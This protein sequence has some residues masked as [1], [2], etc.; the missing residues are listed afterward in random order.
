MQL[1][2]IYQTSFFGLISMSHVGNNRDKPMIT[3]QYQMG[4]L[5]VVTPLSAAEKDPIYPMPKWEEREFNPSYAESAT[6]VAALIVNSVCIA[7]ALAIVIMVVRWWKFT[8][9]KAA[10]P[11]FCL[12]IIL[13]AV[14]MLCSL[15][16][17]TNYDT[18]SGCFVIMFTSLFAKTWPT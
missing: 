16:S 6:E 13:G 14:L 18:D 9:I 8:V 4:E 12:I 5:E 7:Y 10:T 17:W 15:Y 2:R 1:D 11:S 3:V